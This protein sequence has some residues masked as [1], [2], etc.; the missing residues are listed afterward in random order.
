MP[1]PPR[2][3]LRA[4]WAVRAALA[5]ASVAIASAADLVP[6]KIGYERLTLANGR[7]LKHPLIRSFNREAGLIYVLEERQLKPYPATLFPTFVTEAVQRAAAEHPL[8]AEK[9]NDVATVAPE[10]APARPAVHPHSPEGIADREAE[11]QAAIVQR[12]G[13]AAA[14]HFR[15]DTHNGSGYSVL[16]DAGIDLEDIEAVPGWTNQYRVRGRAGYAFYDSVGGTFNTRRRNVEVL[17]EAKSPDR[18]RVLD[19]KTVWGSAW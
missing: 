14:D 9:L 11:L 7:V 3:L 13:R 2:S 5:A 18:I 16:T 10:T 15:Y 17:V 1:R 8:P 19:V 4:R 12:A 6:L